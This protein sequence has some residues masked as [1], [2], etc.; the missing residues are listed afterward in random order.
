M[1]NPKIEACPFCG[2][3]GK[4]VKWP[5]PKMMDGSEAWSVECDA[6]HPAN[7]PSG[8]HYLTRSAEAALAAWNARAGDHQPVTLETE[9]VKALVSARCSLLSWERQSEQRMRG[10]LSEHPENT[11]F[12]LDAEP[13]GSVKM[14]GAFIP[15][16]EE[17]EIWE[18]RNAQAAAERYLMD[19]LKTF[20]G[21]I[22]A[23]S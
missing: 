14:T 20:I 19:W 13:D 1:N 18:I 8:R 7:C 3:P 22:A 21:A 2:G 23:N 9:C 12:I 11:L 5:V 6:P 16:A 17:S 4:L 15:D 10:Y